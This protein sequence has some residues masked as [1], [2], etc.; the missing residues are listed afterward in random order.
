[1]SIKTPIYFLEAFTFGDVYSA[2]ADRVRFTTIDNQFAF[3]ADLIT[4]GRIDGWAVTISDLPTLEISVSAGS[5][6]IDRFMTRTFGPLPLNLTANRE[7]F[8]YMRRKVGVIGGSSGFSNIGEI[9]ITDSTAPAAVGG[10][11]STGTTTSSIDLK[12]TA[13]TEIDMDFYRLERSLNNMDFDTVKELDHPIAQFTDTGLSENTLYYYRISAFDQSGN[14]STVSSSLTIRTAKN[15]TPPLNPTGLQSFPGDELVQLFWRPSATGEENILRYEAHIQSLDNAL[16]PVGAVAIATAD[17]SD[18]FMVIRDLDNNTAYG[19]TLFAVSNNSIFSPGVGVI[20]I[21]TFND[22]PEEVQDISV[23][24]SEGDGD[25]NNVVLDVDWTPFLSPYVPLPSSFLLTFVENGAITFDPIAVLDGVTSRMVQVL[26]VTDDAG[27]TRFRSIKENTPYLLLIRA[28]DETGKTSNGI[29]LSFRTPSFKTPPPVT[30]LSAILTTANSFNVTWTNSKSKFFSHNL[31]SIKRIDLDTDAETIII[32]AVDIGRSS[33][34]S[35]DSSHFLTNNRFEFTVQPVDSFGNTGQPITASFTTIDST[36]IDRPDVPDGQKIIS[37]DGSAKLFWNIG[38]AAIISSYR[39]WRTEF[40]FFLT[41]DDFVIVDTVPVGITE[42]EDFSVNNGE[43]YAYFA[44]SIDVFGQESLNP[45]DDEFISHTLLIATPKKSSTFNA[46]DNLT[47]VQSGFDAVLSWTVTSAEQF[48]GFE[49][50]RSVGNKYSFELIATATPSDTMYTDTNAL[51][52]G[53]TAYHYLIRKYRDEAAPIVTESAAEPENSILLAKVTTTLASISIDEEPA[54]EIKNIEDPVRK[55]TIKQLNAHKHTLDNDG[56]D[57]RIDLNSNVIVTGWETDNFFEYTTETDISGAASAT[58][59]LNGEP[60]DVLH[61][62]DFE[63]GRLTFEKILFTTDDLKEAQIA[64]YLRSIATS[65]DNLGLTAEQR[66]VFEDILDFEDNANQGS[67]AEQSQRLDAAFRAALILA[68]RAGRVIE[69]DVILGFSSPPIVELELLGISEVQNT[70]DSDRIDGI[71]AVQ[72]DSGAIGKRHL[73]EINHHGRMKQK[74]IPD[75]VATTADDG[76]LFSLDSENKIGS[77][78]TFYDVLKVSGDKLLS[79]NSNG[80]WLSEDFGTS[81][82]L[83]F[84]P[85]TAPSKLFYSPELD[86]YLALTNRGIY[87]NSGNL[88]AVWAKMPGLENVSV[89]RDIARDAEGILYTSTNLGVY[90]LDPAIADQAFTWTQTPIFGPKSTESY[91]LLFDSVADRVL[92]SN[93][94]GILE[95]TTAGQSW[96]FTSEFDEIKV[97]YAFAAD[98]GSIFALSDDSIWRKNSGNFV[99][100]ADLDGTMAR[101]MQV[102]DSRI[103]I[104]TD[105]GLLASLSTENIYSDAEITMS[106]IMPQINIKNNKVMVTGLSLV[107]SLLLVLADQR[108]FSRDTSGKIWLVFNNATGVIPTV[109]AN[110]VEQKIGYRYSNVNNNV[111]F[112]IKQPIDTVVTVANQYKRF[113]LESGGWATHKYDSEI[114]TR[115]NNTVISLIDEVSLDSASF[116]AFKF[117]VATERNSHL[118]GAQ[119]AQEDA[120]AK[121]NRAFDIINNVQAEDEGQELPADAATLDEGEALHDVVRDAFLS[122]EKFLSML[123]DSARV[124]EIDDGE[125]PVILP[126][127]SVSDSDSGL[128][129]NITTGEFVFATEFDRYDNL[130][131]DIVG[132][133][134]L[135][136]GENTHRELE[137][138]LELVNSGLP[139]SLSQV[140]DA[141]LVKSGI[142]NEKHWPDEPEALSPSFQAKYIVPRSSSFYDRLNSTIDYEVQQSIEDI[143][144]SLPSVSDAIYMN[145]NNKAFVGGKGGLLSIDPGNFDIDEIQIGNEVNPFVK[146]LMLRNG[147][148][149]ALLEKELYR[150]LDAGDN[151]EKVERSGLPNRLYKIVNIANALVVGA[152][153]GIYYKAE[154]QDSWIK[155]LD[156]DLPVEIMI[157]PDAVFAM[158]DGT[159]YRSTNGLNFFNIGSK[160]SVEVNALSKFKSVI[161]AGTQTGLRRDDGTF[162]SITSANLSIV[163]LESDLILSDDIKIN[164]VDSDSTGL[165]AGDAEGNYYVLNSSGN[166]DKLTNSNLETIHKVLVVDGEGW[167]F[168][169]DMLKIPSLP[170]PI[171]LSTGAPL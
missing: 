36:G 97:L 53:G 109:Y 34:Y 123:F 92:V 67:I 131:A 132:A 21:P 2:A 57:R 45:V 103:F 90:R 4:D 68:G 22:G 77:A 40:K 16:N 9:T 122:I 43:Q 15:L 62:V 42:Y 127:I 72:I 35:L 13:N 12:W 106:P 155:A 78:V 125:V 56:T 23:I 137:D 116:A 136:I 102:F 69:R 91:G 38:D 37:G 95:T 85:E 31:I 89:V 128:T 80:V 119:S 66:K 133:T 158:V 25:D 152:E 111:S 7:V 70:L 27:F 32:S 171:R 121:I 120:Q 8:V 165:V 99:K 112:D 100:L 61:T 142:F 17:S 161:F 3:L 108:I 5:G 134:V 140:R 168:G 86:K 101:H 87:A 94:F 156:S 88:D 166:F 105:L 126:V 153:D 129:I 55:E 118:S 24:F 18:T 50:F 169:F 145:S 146:S 151:W 46:P 76:F 144:L 81:W 60:T 49:I 65:K 104:T 6:L 11:T 20:S 93:E 124:I 154:Q 47:V 59:R 150:S 83:L 28:V 33:N 10:L 115:A 48:D 26:P 14:Q 82:R 139:S 143:T 159:V 160:L 54:N 164:D 141:N 19:I 58:V 30:N 170:N 107:E 41:P 167:L 1:M 98:G 130:E 138:A 51:L 64:A 74:L 52:R 113:T 149:Y 114:V 110:A 44:T 39:I 162:Y 96:S 157:N 75:Q 117:P 147:A 63:N 148:I 29:I 71:S 73:P 135:N 84:T 79:A 163:D